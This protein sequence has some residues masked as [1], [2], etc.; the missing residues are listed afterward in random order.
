MLVGGET[1]LSGNVYALNPA[2]GIYGPVCDDNWDIE[3]VSLTY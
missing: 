2:T 1:E 3:D